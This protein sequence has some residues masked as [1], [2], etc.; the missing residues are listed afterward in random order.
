MALLAPRVGFFRPAP[1]GIL[2]R[3][4]AVLGE[5]EVLGQLALVVAPEGAHGV[6]RDATDGTL[7]RRPVGYGDPLVFVD[8]D[9]TGVDRQLV[10]EAESEKG[11]GT[12]FKSPTSGRYYGRP[13]PD[14]EPFVKV[15]DVVTRGQT[16]ALLEVMKTF[17]RVSYGGAHLPERARVLLVVPENEADL[18]AGD[19]I[20]EIEAEG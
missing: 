17:N 10:A 7:A 5:L 18:S 9:V 2:V 12:V 20:L 13:S 16:V 3:P 1:A 8:T 4:G 14:A 6:T 15:G 19:P 11:A